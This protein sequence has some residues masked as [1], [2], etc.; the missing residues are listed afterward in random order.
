[1]ATIALNASIKEV[2]RYQFEVEV[3]D[4]LTEEQQDEQAKERVKK[5]LDENIPYPFQRDFIG[6]VKCVDCE[7]GIS[8]EDVVSIEVNEK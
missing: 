7:S 8:M 2:N 4:N 6:G 5:F 3:D 1:M